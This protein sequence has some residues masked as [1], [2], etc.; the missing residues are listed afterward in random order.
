MHPH[1]EIADSLR[2]F[3]LFVRSNPEKCGASQALC[4]FLLKLPTASGCLDFFCAPAPKIAGRL[5]LFP[6]FSARMM[7]IADRLR[8]F[9]LIGHATP[10]NGGTSRGLHGNG[11]IADRLKL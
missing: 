7:K 2:L 9:A 3:A 11:A 10:E 5:R 6:L 1:D 8:L 4:T